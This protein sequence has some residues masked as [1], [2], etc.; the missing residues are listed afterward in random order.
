MF[1][2]VWEE[3]TTINERRP[4]YSIK[5]KSQ[6]SIGS[7]ERE[8]GSNSSNQISRNTCRVRTRKKDLKVSQ[9]I[10]SNYSSGESG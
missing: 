5:G 1:E 2:E 9:K 7:K 3:I 4:Y 10:R 8:T 6:K